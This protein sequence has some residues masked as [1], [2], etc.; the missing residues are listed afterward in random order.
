MVIGVTG[1][2]F[3]AAV[4]AARALPATGGG[5][6]DATMEGQVGGSPKK[7]KSEAKDLIGD[8]MRDACTDGVPQFAGFGAAKRARSG[9]ARRKGREIADE[10]DELKSCT[11]TTGEEYVKRSDLEALLEG[12]QKQNV[13]VVAGLI[14]GYDGTL[15]SRFAKIENDMLD[16]RSRQDTVEVEQREMRASLDKLSKSLAVAVETPQERIAE[17]DEY[18]RQIDLA[19]FRINAQVLVEKAGVA[20]ELLDWLE[21]AGMAPAEYEL[22]GPALGKNFVLRFLGGAGGLPAR[23]AKKAGQMLRDGGVWKRFEVTSPA[24][25]RVPIF[26]GGDKNPRQIATEKAVKELRN[27]LV[28]AHPGK[29][30]HML[31]RDGRIQLD[32]A[33]VARC[34]PQADGH[35]VVEWAGNTVEKEGINKEEVLRIFRSSRQGGASSAISWTC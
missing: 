25:G 6:K 26:I 11:S 35:M 17:T 24:E 22:E 14:R 5:G 7:P 34:R 23:R 16:V 8:A 10:D 9:S 4:M 12:Y 29:K 13:G 28:E 15:Q 18:D 33:P 20:K 30:W 21:Q 2:V 3:I 31:K 32:F 1:S 19:I 27:A